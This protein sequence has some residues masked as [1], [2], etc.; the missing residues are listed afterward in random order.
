MSVVCNN[1]SGHLDAILGAYRD[2][3]AIETQKVGPNTDMLAMSAAWSKAHTAL[4]R[5]LAAAEQCRMAKAA[6]AH[7]QHPIPTEL[8]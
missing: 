1:P 3:L 5:T 8:P 6:I 2:F 4:M 7:R